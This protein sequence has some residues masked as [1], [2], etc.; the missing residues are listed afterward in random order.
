MVK[1]FKA[2]VAL[3]TAVIM[4]FASLCTADAAGSYFSKGG[5]YFG[6]Q[7]DEAY[8]HGS[9]GT[10]WDI[11]IPETFLSFYVTSIEGY[12]FYDNQTI[13]KLSFYEASQLSLLGDGAFAHCHKL[14]Q[15]HITDTI[16]E[17]GIGVFEDCTA[18]SDVR[19]RDGAM[20]NVPAQCFYGCTALKNVVFDNR[21]TSIGNLAFANCSALTKLELPDS[22]VSIADNA[23]N[24]CD[25]I[26]IYCSFGSYAHQYAMANNIDYVFTDSSYILGDSDNSGAVNVIDATLIQKLLIGKKSDPYGL[27][28]IRG[29]VNGDKKISIRDATLIQMH[30]SGVSVPYDIAAKKEFDP[31]A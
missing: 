13:E 29:D 7:G 6:I 23:F 8:I 1:R 25:D 30:I 31:A 21:L 2:T 17:M 14:G 5:F 16:Q 15:V 27:I 19:F 24:G 9:D 26:K 12:A 18:L 22:V 4:L 10:G 20:T 11:V 28:A 3:I